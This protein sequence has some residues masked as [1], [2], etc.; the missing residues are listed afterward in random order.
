MSGRRRYPKDFPYRG[1]SPEH[2][3]AAVAHYGED[4][5]EALLDEHI[6]LE[7]R[8]PAEFTDYLD[9]FVRYWPRKGY[10]VR[11]DYLHGFVQPK[12]KQKGQDGT[13]S[14]TPAVA[15][16]AVF[17]RMLDPK[18]W[19][20]T[21]GKE[22]IRPF[23][24]ALHAPKKTRLA[25]IDLDNK[26]GVLGYYHAGPT[27][28]AP[29]RPIPSVTVE[30]LRTVKAVYEQFPDR[31]WCISSATLGLHI[32]ETRRHP[33]LTDV[34]QERTKNLLVGIGLGE[35][36]VHP[37]VGRP[38]RRPF[39]TDYHTI[40]DIGL[41]SN[42]IDQVRFFK[43][44]THVPTFPAVVKAML[45]VCRTEWAS[46]DG[47]LLARGTRLEARTLAR[48]R[49]EEVQRWLDDG[50]PDTLVSTP[51]RLGRRE[52]GSIRPARQ[53]DTASFDITKSFDGE[54]VQSCVRWARDGL[55]GE[56]SIFPVTSQLAR[57]LYFVEIWDVTDEDRLDQIKSLLISFCDK[58]NNGFISRV[59][60]G[61]WSDVKRQIA[62]IV[63]EAVEHTDEAGHRIFAGIRAKRA[64]GR[65]ATTI[66]LAP[67]LRSDPDA[68]TYLQ[69]DKP[70]KKRERTWSITPDYSPLP[71]KLTRE[72]ED[73][74]AS[75]KTELQR[76]RLKAISAFMNYLWGRDGRARLGTESLRKLGFN[77]YKA[78]LHLRRLQAMGLIVIGG[79]SK[80]C[81]LGR[82]FTM[83]DRCQKM[84]EL[85]RRG[86]SGCS[87]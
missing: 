72:I 10:H 47:K 20:L 67:L 77:G 25:A 6:P 22:D 60:Q 40:I 45:S 81:G 87:S 79:F 82:E 41:V 69:T 11:R 55:P 1:I 48:R 18:R 76:R 70:N 74:Y 44:P 39:G 9:L 49:G 52:A 19:S 46:S 43:N 35:T 4:R 65:Y 33:E 80:A 15:Y 21:S 26:A 50:C 53:A 14:E 59:K 58:K 32:W 37:M 17:A 75:N 84:F 5:A 56:D 38:F 66:H 51:S 3:A 62:R 86:R 27:R 12:W 34:V 71:E 24:V 31:I 16:D 30:H 36:E 2:V 57:W 85:H 23:W 64:A 61:K 7:R 73:Y 78:R 8:W 29:A 83:T 13:I 28:E 54:W 68:Q 63:N 42:W